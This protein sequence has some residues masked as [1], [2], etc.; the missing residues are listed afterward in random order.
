VAAMER[1]SFP[2]ALE[3]LSGIRA[4]AHSAAEAAGLD[5]KATYSLQLAV[6]EIAT[7]IIAHGYQESGLQGDLSIEADSTGEALT[8]TLRDR[9]APFDPRTLELPDE[10]AL[11]KPLEERREGGL[12]IFLAFAGV[13]RFDYHR[14]GDTNVNIFVVNR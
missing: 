10:E 4:Y 14:E 1:K 7:N 11:A 8:V 6:D 2:A 13:D 3:S 12:G 9:G 5:G